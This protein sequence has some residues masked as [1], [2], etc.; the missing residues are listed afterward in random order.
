MI[1]LMDASCVMF[2][3]LQDRSSIKGSNDNGDRS[4]RAK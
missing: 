2:S 3:P 4:A 1:R